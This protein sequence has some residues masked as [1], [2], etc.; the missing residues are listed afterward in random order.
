MIF[1]ALV[2]VGITLH[3]IFSLKFLLFALLCIPGVVVVVNDRIYLYTT[4]ILYIE[5][6]MR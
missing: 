5:R 3:A 1:I 2:K 4:R 6:T